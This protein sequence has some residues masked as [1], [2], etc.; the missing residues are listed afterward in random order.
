MT[1]MARIK[2]NIDVFKSL[3]GNQFNEVNLNKSAPKEYYENWCGEVIHH[4]NPGVMNDFLKLFTIE[5]SNGNIYGIAF[6]FDY[7]DLPQSEH[8]IQYS[9]KIKDQKHPK[10]TIINS[11]KMSINDF[12]DKLNEVNTKLKEKSNPT[13]MEVITTLNNI[14]ISDF[15]EKVKAAKYTKKNRIK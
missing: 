9:I 8:K 1:P 11:D 2:N 4:N 15:D 6:I 3:I 10:E 7:I 13:H 5:F 12:K 14:Y